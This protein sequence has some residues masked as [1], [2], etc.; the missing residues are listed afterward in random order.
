MQ[1]TASSVDE[2][3]DKLDSKWKA[4]IIKLRT[5]IKDNIPEGFV[6]TMSYGMIGYVVP[7]SKYQKGYHVTP[8]LPLPFINIAAQKNYIA[9]YHMGL[10]GNQKLKDWFVDEYQ[11]TYNRK[12]DMGK[13][14]FRFNKD[15]NVPY[16]LIKELV[17][18]ISIE[19]YIQKYEELLKTR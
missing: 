8:N 13:G 15:E 16:E 12:M 4:G 6:E 3:I 7:H 11:K 2:Y 17:R 1:S 18:K 5:I 10:N 9:L 19:A 14:C